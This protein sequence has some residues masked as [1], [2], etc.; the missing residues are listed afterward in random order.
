MADNNF[1][2]KCGNSIGVGDLFC[3]KCGKS[4]QDGVNDSQRQSLADLVSTA[5]PSKSLKVSFEDKSLQELYTEA[6]IL[7]THHKYKQSLALLD[8]KLKHNN[9]KESLTRGDYINI[10]ML[11]RELSYL[12]GLD[13]AARITEGEIIN[14]LFM[15][16]VL[17]TEYLEL[18]P[19]K[20]Y[21]ENKAELIL[22]E[23]ISTH[24]RKNSFYIAKKYSKQHIAEV[25]Q[26]TEQNP[27]SISKP[28]GQ[29]SKDRTWVKPVAIASLVV[30]SFFVF[31]F[32]DH[33]SVLYHW[34]SASPDIKRIANG[35]GLS[36]KGM[37]AFLG[38]NPEVVGPDE[39]QANC[40]QEN[41][42]VVEFGCYIPAQN[43]IYILRAPSSEYESF[44]Y[45]TA[46]HEALHVIWF[47]LSSADR[48]L[49]KDKL[50]DIY[51]DQSGQFHSQLKED[52]QP[53]GGDEDIVASELYAFI[54]S[55][56][57]T[58]MSDDYAAYFLDRY[59]SASA[60]SKFENAMKSKS[61]SLEAR[62]KE[63]EARIAEIELFHKNYVANYENGYVY[64]SQYNYGIYQQNYGKYKE[65]YDRWE[66]DRVR[67]N[68]EVD[69]F[70]TTRKAFYPSDSTIQTL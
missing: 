28:P 40:K 17:M 63:L 47:N 29:R 7:A 15:R 59:I 69:S 60:D 10:L 8:S 26:V 5:G 48:A 57:P 9:V 52:I 37:A 35:S 13:E 30:V 36:P 54:G 66:A 61:D 4:V 43:K 45:S 51:L 25:R 23:I 2:T 21:S 41:R 16:E 12:E 27:S 50:M 55:A 42:D 31:I 49:L 62:R 58:I 65:R 46:A 34:Q 3:T 53:Y 33:L 44:Q 68:F 67:F 70:N 18:D 56:Y 32:Y 14:T 64:R 11:Y 22:R 24:Q 38:T 1:C 6:K 19:G 39:L 20:A